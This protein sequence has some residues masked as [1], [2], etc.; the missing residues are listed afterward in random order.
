MNP[1]LIQ[2]G[3]IEIRWYAVFIIINIII[4]YIMIKYEAH[5][6]GI[7]KDLIFNM[8][9][10]TIILGIVGARLYYVIFN[11]HLYRNNLGE[12]V[13][14]WKGGLAIH[15][16]I[17]G[18]ALVIIYYAKRYKIEVLRL[19]DIFVVPLI[20]GQAIGR[21]GN[22]FNSEAHGPATTLAHL[23]SLKIPEFIIKGMNIGGVY[24]T[25]TFLY[26]SLWCILGFIILLIV[27]KNKYIKVGQL[28][29]I[30]F[31]WYSFGR[32]IIEAM[33]T[34]S[35]MFLGFKVAQLVSVTLFI[36]GTVIYIYK[37]RKNKFEDLYNSDS[38]KIRY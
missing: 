12:I 34:D 17:I 27:R 33:R 8:I 24:Y 21:W 1:I 10:W 16:G 2:I 20:L 19:F 35:L 25:P 5:R 28:T 14:M 26:E 23:K 38:E 7:Q 3:N 18:G 29:A 11:F 31:M 37:S 6:F 9:F 22:F 13:Q 32:F 36:A 30:Y 15:G 4:G